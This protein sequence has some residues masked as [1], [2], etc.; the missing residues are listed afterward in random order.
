MEPDSSVQDPLR[1]GRSEGGLLQTLEA[2]NHGDANAKYELG[3]MYKSG[4]GEAQADRE[5]ALQWF[6][7][8]ALAG[9]PDAMAQVGSFYAQGDGGPAG[10]T[11]ALFWYRKARAAKSAGGTLALAEMTCQGTGITKDV[12]GCGDL[13]NEAVHDLQP[14]D[15]RYEMLHELAV[16]EIA[17]G[18]R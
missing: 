7:E 15:A 16:Q 2:A 18:K 14:S 4:T 17:M 8:A 1:N 6:E 12:L 10:T 9:V 3:I 5:R 11:Q 13:L